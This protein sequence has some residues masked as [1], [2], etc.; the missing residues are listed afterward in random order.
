ML[1]TAS[2]RGSRRETLSSYLKPRALYARARRRYDGSNF[3]SCAEDTGNESQR[4][5]GKHWRYI[6]RGENVRSVEPFDIDEIKVTDKDYGAIQTHGLVDHR[7][8][9]VILQ[10]IQEAVDSEAERG[11]TSAEEFRSGGGLD[12]TQLLSELDTKYGHKP[13][14]KESIIRQI[15]R[16]S[17]VSN[18]IKEKYG[19][20]CQLCGYPGFVKKGGGKYA[21]VHHMLELNNLAPRTLQSWNIL[22]VCALCHRKLHYAEAKTEFLNPGWRISMEGKE[23]VLRA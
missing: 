3:V 4:I 7:D 13:E 12:P 23:Y 16:P 1:R 6:I 20:K 15:Q 17:A 19:Y 2:H 14:F 18:A 11:D 8:E 22:V 10:W 5:W 21:E 9:E